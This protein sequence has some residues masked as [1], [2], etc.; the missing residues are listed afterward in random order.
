VRPIRYVPPPNSRLWAK[1]KQRGPGIK[2]W[3]RYPGH[4]RAFPAGTAYWDEDASQLHVF[5]GMSWLY[6]PLN[7][8]RDTYLLPSGEHMPA[9]RLRQDMYLAQV[10]RNSSTLAQASTYRYSWHASGASFDVNGRNYDDLYDLNYYAAFRPT[11]ARD[12]T[13]TPADLP[14]TSYTLHSPPSCPDQKDT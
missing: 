5:D 14:A 1:C 10:G 8:S 11:R 13:I 6:C 4:S 12:V 2:A 9:E 3:T 7:Y